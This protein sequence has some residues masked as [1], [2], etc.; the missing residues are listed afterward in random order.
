MHDEGKEYPVR[1]VKVSGKPVFRVY[2]RVGIYYTGTSNSAE[3]LSRFRSCSGT[4]ADELYIMLTPARKE[5][6]GSIESYLDV[7]IIFVV[8]LGVFYID[9]FGSFRNSLP[10][11][12]FLV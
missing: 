1:R 5:F 7:C 4:A 2:I 10:M 9:F 12:Q 3:D 6:H 11:N 8:F